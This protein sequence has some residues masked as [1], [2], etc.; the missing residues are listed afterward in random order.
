M[1]YIFSIIL[2]GSVC[3]SS[4]FAV[5]RLSKKD[6]EDLIEMFQEFIDGMERNETPIKQQVETRWSLWNS[7]MT[8]IEKSIDALTQIAQ[9]IQNNIAINEDSAGKETQQKILLNLHEIRNIL[10]AM[11]QE[12]VAMHA[13]LGDLDDESLGE[14]EFNSVQ[15]IDNATESLITWLKSIFRE[16]LKDKFIS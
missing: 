1:K 11:L 10:Q 4:V 3:T 12:L 9:Q 14:Q 13:V 15:D 2:L 7:P 16:Q 6:K 8:R 5:Q